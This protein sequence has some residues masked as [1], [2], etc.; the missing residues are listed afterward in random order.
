LERGFLL[1]DDMLVG[2]E[3]AAAQAAYNRQMEPARA[4]WLDALAR[5]VQQGDQ[6]EGK[7]VVIAVGSFDPCDVVIDKF[8]QL[9]SLLIT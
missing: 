9:S 5:G 6:F 4:Q 1:V 7:E 8:R 2:G 3:L